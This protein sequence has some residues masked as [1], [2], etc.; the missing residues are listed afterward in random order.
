MAVLYRSQLID[1]LIA[2]VNGEWR[3]PLLREGHVPPIIGRMIDPTRPLTHAGA[4][5]V[6]TDRGGPEYL[7]VSSSD[8]SAWVLPKGHI[9]PGEEARTTALRELEEE[10][11]VRGSVV[12]SLPTQRFH[13]GSEEIVVGYYL[14]KAEDFGASPEGREL[15]WESEAGAMKRLTFEDARAVIRE[16]LAKLQGEPE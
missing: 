9:E 4:L 10:A 5:A 3:N 13:R 12:A 15:R 14:V 16:A 2:E 11:G 1:D 7:V 8:G 6:R